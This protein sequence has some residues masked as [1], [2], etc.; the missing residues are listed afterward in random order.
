[1]LDTLDHAEMIHLILSFL[2]NLPE[3][4]LEDLSPKLKAKRRQSIDML[5]KSALVEDNPTPAIYSLADLILNSLGSKN[6]Q[7]TAATLRL[8]STILRKHYP[9]AVGTLLKTTPLSSTAP[10]RTIGAYNAEIDLLFS[11]VTD[12]SEENSAAETYEG[13]L[14]DVLMLLE[15]HPCSARLLGLKPSVSAPQPE[16]SI[17]DPMSRM[18]I[19][20]IT[21]ADPLL[22]GLLDLL[23]S[24]FANPVEINLV[25]TAAIIDLAACAWMRPEGWLYFD[26]KYYTYP[27]LPVAKP[28]LNTDLDPSSDNEADDDSSDDDLSDLDSELA[29]IL[30]GATSTNSTT[31]SADPFST[32]SALRQSALTD[33]RRR[34]LLDT[35]Y[36]PV[37]ATVKA[38][39]KQVATFRGSIP[40]FDE[41]LKEH[42]RSF[43]V[44]EG[45]AEAVNTATSTPTGSVVGGSTPRK[46]DPFN[47]RSLVSRASRH[48]ISTPSPVPATARRVG[49]ERLLNVHV[50]PVIIATAEPRDTTRDRGMSL[51]THLPPPPEGEEDEEDEDEGGEG[52]GEGER[53]RREE[54]E[55]RRREDEERR[56]KEERTRPIGLVLTNVMVLQEF[57]LEL[58]A[59]TQARGSLFGDI[60]YA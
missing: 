35:N 13:H 53:R 41:R 11:F 43:E 22:K 23:A 58:A 21:A 25:L 37:L 24:F 36:P 31:S 57:V 48:T 12:I 59:L 10:S 46:L 60:K 33:S 55:R 19:H 39:V 30:S 17:N 27:Q 29:A 1:M 56:E 9:Y 16:L 54:E 45:V 34:P 3:K 5:S 47:P 14:R 4:P 2:M 38:L 49:L 18:H 42:R 20:T 8:T 28:S 50:P 51:G 15:S 32:K 26:P 6:Q 44:Q 52:D 40:D 7:T